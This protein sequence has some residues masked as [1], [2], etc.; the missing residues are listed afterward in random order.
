MTLMREFGDADNNGLRVC[1][2]PKGLHSV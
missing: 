1:G 2:R